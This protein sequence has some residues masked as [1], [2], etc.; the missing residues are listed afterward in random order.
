MSNEMT[1]G[2]VNRRQFSWA[3]LAGSVVVAADFLIFS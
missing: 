2:M 1:H 3:A